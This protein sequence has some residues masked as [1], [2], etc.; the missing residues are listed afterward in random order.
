[1]FVAFALAG[2]A[3]TEQGGDEALDEWRGAAA[4]ATR[5]CRPDGYGVYRRG[6]ARFGFMVEFDR[7]TERLDEYVAKFDA[8]YTYRDSGQAARDYD[9][10]P[11]LLCITTDPEAEGLMADAAFRVW[12]RRGGEPLPILLTTTQQICDH[13]EGILGPVWL[14]PSQHGNQSAR[15][16]WL[17]GGP[18]HGL[19]GAGRRIAPVPRF[20]W[21]TARN[22]ARHRSQQKKIQCAASKLSRLPKP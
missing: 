8:Y 16:Y 12:Y 10:I 11:T 4:C 13:P 3:A 5:H 7:G 21:P 6:A 22:V 9:G 15:G 18:P 14:T 1:V 20:L 2:R 17:P 19:F